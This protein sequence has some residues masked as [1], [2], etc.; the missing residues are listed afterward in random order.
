MQFVAV[1]ADIPTVEFYKRL[2]NLKDQEGTNAVPQDIVDM[3]EWPQRDGALISKSL[4]GSIER[5]Y[6]GSDD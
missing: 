3:A 1:G 2:D 5:S 4:L 6:D